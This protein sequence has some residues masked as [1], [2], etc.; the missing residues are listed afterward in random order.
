MQNAFSGW[1]VPRPTWGSNSTT[2]DSLDGFD[3]HCHNKGTLGL[4]CTSETA[5]KAAV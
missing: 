1:T 3:R 5:D 2:P 4:M